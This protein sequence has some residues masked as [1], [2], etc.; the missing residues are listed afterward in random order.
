M[1]FYV[2]E[3]YKNQVKFIGTN[4]AANNTH[5]LRDSVEMNLF[6]LKQKSGTPMT[7]CYM[8]NHSLDEI[9][10]FL[11]ELDC[12]FTEC[13]VKMHNH[14]IMEKFCL[15]GDANFDTTTIQGQDIIE[16]IEQQFGLQLL[17]PTNPISATTNWCFTNVSDN[18]VK[19]LHIK[20]HSTIKTLYG[21]I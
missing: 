7:I 6:K 21:S 20:V 2:R 10:D 17:L 8:K 9:E 12:F 13:R 3:E 11:I 1:A 5:T 16:S 14:K 4:A 19:I 15:I 18:N